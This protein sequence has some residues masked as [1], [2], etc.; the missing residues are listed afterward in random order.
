MHFVQVVF[1]VILYLKQNKM[2]LLLFATL[3]TPLIVSGQL[4]EL[5]G[6]GIFNPGVLTYNE[7]KQ[8][9]AAYSFKTVTKRDDYNKQKSKRKVFID[10]VFDSSILV[11]DIPES[12][13]FLPEYKSVFISEYEVSGIKMKSISLNF[14]NDTLIRLYSEGSSQ[15]QDALKTKYG[16][17]VLEQIETPS[18][19]NTSLKNK[20]YTESWTNNSIRASAV[21]SSSYGFNCQ[22]SIFQMFYLSDTIKLDV[23]S[24]K[25]FEVETR[26][27]NKGS[28]GPNNKLKD[29]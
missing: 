19:C 16:K 12:A 7:L 4:S 2:R 13:S 17:G 29:F 1:F 11:K 28:N 25:N 14:L 18:T 27:T 21:L 22:Q 3:I 5:R 23:F 6:V 8:Y 20:M 15:L 9:C 24:K 10:V 26:L